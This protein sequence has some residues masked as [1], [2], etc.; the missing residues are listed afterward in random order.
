M[1]LVCVV[2]TEA[3]AKEARLEVTWAQLA[4][5][6]TICNFNTTLLPVTQSGEK[7]LVASWTSGGRVDP[8]RH[9]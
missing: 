8:S 3:R 4:C 1:L 5:V 2:R 6:G 9:C 7:Q